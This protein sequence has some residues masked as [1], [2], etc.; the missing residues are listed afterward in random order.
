MTAL[1]LMAAAPSIR[2]IR[3]LASFAA[4]AE[5]SQNVVRA[6]LRRFS[7]LQHSGVLSAALARR[8]VMLSAARFTVVVLMAGQTAEA[9]NAPIPL[10]H[11]AAAIPFVVLACV[12]AVT[13][14]GIGVNELTSASALRIFGTPFSIGA[15]WAV[16]N[17][18]LGFAACFLAAAIA[19]AALGIK[20]LGA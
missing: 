16:A 12:L 10:W 4:N 20:R 7:R 15:Q 13:P 19:A 5:G 6:I 17:R 11:L 3:W 9:I 14:G 1:A 8:L 18:V 2:L